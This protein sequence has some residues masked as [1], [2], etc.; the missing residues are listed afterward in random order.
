MAAYHVF[1]ERARA[2][3]P[4]GQQVLADAVAERYGLPAAQIAERLAAGKMR[5]KTNVDLATAETFAADLEQLGAVCAIVDAETGATVARAQA[6]V[7]PAIRPTTPP[8]FAAPKVAA[9]PAA[10][11]PP[12]PTAPKAAA[13]AAPAAKAPV[14][15]TSGLSAAYSGTATDADLGALGSGEL[16]LS[17]LDGGDE[18]PS[19]S[20]SMPASFEPPVDATPA[21]MRAGRPSASPVRQEP[22]DLFAPPDSEGQPELEVLLDVRAERRGG[23]TAPPQTHAEPATVPVGR[24]ARATGQ[25]AS[26]PPLASAAPAT[27]GGGL[28]ARLADAR[29]RLAAGAMLAILLGFVPAHI[30]ASMRE[31]PAYAAIDRDVARR[32]DPRQVVG[33]DDWAALDGFRAQQL[34]RKEAKQRDIALVALVLWAV[35]S[36]GVGFVWFRVIDWDKLEARLAA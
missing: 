30:F 35:V 28:G 18:Q 27:R 10:P 20:G 5:V 7:A 6:P 33:L 25:M 13:V 11:K 15:F 4:A 8:P 36:A 31:G 14:A 1:I 34:A 32:Q 2:G 16:S 22:I 24:A 3:G 12:A 9:A 17:L 23:T 21:D 19:S 29:V 26:E